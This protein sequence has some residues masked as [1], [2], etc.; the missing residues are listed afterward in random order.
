MKVTPKPIPKE[1]AMG[2]LDALV[3]TEIVEPKEKGKAKNAA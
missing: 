2:L 1:Q 3:P